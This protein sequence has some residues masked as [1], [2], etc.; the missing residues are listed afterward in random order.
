MK[1]KLHCTWL[2]SVV[3]T[4]LPLSISKLRFNFRIRL[5]SRFS[6][7]FTSRSFH[8]VR[9]RF[10]A[11]VLSSF[12]SAVC[13]LSLYFSFSWFQKHRLLS[14]SFRPGHILKANPN[15]FH[16]PNS[17]SGVSII[18]CSASSGFTLMFQTMESILSSIASNAPRYT[19]A[20]KAYLLDVCEKRERDFKDDCF[21]WVLYCGFSKKLEIL[22]I[23]VHATRTDRI[24]FSSAST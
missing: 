9:L 13:A 8:T 1:Y 20:E 12:V 11:R 15:P 6:I 2:P 16:N 14:R 3:Y 22:S 19:A 7:R 24:V 18:D 4:L 21:N 17:K 10:D 5:L 23:S